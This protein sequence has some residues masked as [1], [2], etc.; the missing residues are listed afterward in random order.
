MNSEL[1]KKLELHYV[2]YENDP[3]HTLDAYTRNK[4]EHAFLQIVCEV[5]RELGIHV[6]IQV[7]PH[8][9]GGVRDYYNLI[10]SS[11]GGNVAQWG[12]FILAAITFAM[13]LP[14]KQDSKLKELTIL[15]KELSITKLR[16]EIAAKEHD[17]QIDKVSRS[18]KTGR[19]AKI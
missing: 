5:A 12:S 2:F 17:G 19:G 15:E 3:S 7:E 14:T 10:L 11:K 16:M 18:P 1:S 4:C 8:S 9:E 13:M 6:Q